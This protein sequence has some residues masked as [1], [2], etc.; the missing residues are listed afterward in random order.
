MSQRAIERL[1]AQFG[2]RI[3]ATSA[4]RGDDTAVVAPGDWLA[5]AQFLKSDAECAM[6]AFGL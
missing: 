1:K 5:V 4:F 6:K 2:D 3:L